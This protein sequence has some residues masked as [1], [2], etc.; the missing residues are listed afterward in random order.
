MWIFK[1]KILKS[2]IYKFKKGITLFEENNEKFILYKFNDNN[3]HILKNIC[4]HAGGTFRN[5]DDKILICNYHGWKLNAETCEYINP[6]NVFQDKLYISGISDNENFNYEYP[7]SENEI[8]HEKYFYILE[9]S[10]HYPWLT[11]PVKEKKNIDD[12]EFVITYYSHACV[13]IKCGNFVLFTD[14]WLI[15]PAFLKGWWLIHKP[16]DSWLDDICNADMIWISHHHQ[17]HL[18]QLTLNKILEKNPNIEIVVGDLDVPIFTFFDGKLPNNLQ[19]KKMNT[20]HYINE[21]LRYMILYDGTWRDMD[22]CFYL[23]YKGYTLFTTVDCCNPNLGILPENIDLLMSD[24]AGGASG[25]PT[26]SFGGIYTKEWIEKW[27]FNDRKYTLNHHVENYIKKT[28]AKAYMPYAGFFNEAHPDSNKIKISNWHN[29]SEDFIEYFKN[30]DTKLLI[31]KPGLSY[32]IKTFSSLNIIDEKNIY[33]NYEKFNFNEYKKIYDDYINIQC[34]KNIIGYRNY[35]KWANLKN[36][37]LVLLILELESVDSNDIKHGFYVDFRG[38]IVV[39]SYE[40]PQ[41]IKY[42][43]II[44]VDISSFKYT[45]YE[46]KTWDNLYIGFQMRIARKPD[47]YQKTFWNH[48]NCGLPKNKLKWENLSSN[49]IINDNIIESFKNELLEMSKYDED[50]EEKYKDFVVIYKNNR[51]DIL[52]FL[53]K[54]PGGRVVLENFRNKDITEEFEKIGHSEYAKNL[55]NT[56]K[57]DNKDKEKNKLYFLY[58]KEV[59]VDSEMSKI[60]KITLIDEENKCKCQCECREI[61]LDLEDY[62]LFEIDDIIKPYTPIFYKNYGFLTFIIKI[63]KNG[64]F[65]Q[66]ID[67][68]KINDKLFLSKVKG[69]LSEEILL[70]FKNIIYICGGS[71]ITP[72]FKLLDFYNKTKNYPDKISI[73]NSNKTKE[74]LIDFPIPNKLNIE[75]I[76]IFTSFEKRID[77]DK[78]LD[79][80][81]NKKQLF[82]LCGPDKMISDLNL[83]IDKNFNKST[84]INL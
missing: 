16:P 42:Y 80:F 62:Y 51:Y 6:N 36:Y 8:D 57:I 65:T 25:Y 59:I 55:L 4:K 44:K 50:K 24:F 70:N 38:E 35:F 54:H 3:F 60:I 73:L 48:F 27:V 28:K 5:E 47:I 46:C 37:D 49:E 81:E 84:I 7:Y 58:K 39:V 29:K 30:V 19:K 71:G 17:D 43:E 12:D 32:S 82:I 10:P 23:D 15:G 56:F 22:T 64:L 69:N 63:Y 33:F 53:N 72:L 68:L 67:K 40:K 11:N 13:K 34:L 78:L 21:D 26:T 77:E 9:Y 75:I 83:C 31:P 2:K 45:I 61:K 20:W 41:N 66:K 1:F 14:P 76:N 18:N 79:L 74:D 52:D